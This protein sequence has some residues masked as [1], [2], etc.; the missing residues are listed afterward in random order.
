[1][2]RSFKIFQEGDIVIVNLQRMQT[3]IGRI[4]S[5]PDY[6]PGDP[7]PIYLVRLPGYQE[8]TLVYESELEH[9]PTPGR[10]AGD[11]LWALLEP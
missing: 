8:D 5:R 1:M 3:R 9:L 6:T 10:R 2:S 7:N 11:L 4:E